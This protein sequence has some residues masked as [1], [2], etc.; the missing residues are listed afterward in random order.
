MMRQPR[1]L[2]LALVAMLLTTA[3]TAASEIYAARY[4]PQPERPYLSQPMDVRL[5][6]EVSPGAEL[7]ELKL[8][9]LPLE[10]FAKLSSYQ[11]VE[12]RQIRRG[13]AVVEVISYVASGRPVQPARQD[14]RGI[15]HAQLVERTSLGFFTSLRSVNTS[16][17]MEPLRLDFRPLPPT[18]VPT[19]FQ[20]AVGT[21]QLSATVDPPQVLPGDLITVTYSVTGRGW[22]GAAHIL[23]P[24]SDPNF[25]SYP[26]QELQRDENGQLSVRQVVVPLNTNAASLGAARLPYFDPA[27]GVYRESVAGPFRLQF[28]TRA[29]TNALPAVKHFQV[30]PPPATPTANGDAA[31][32]ATVT[33]LRRLLPFAT[34]FLVAMLSAGLLYGWRPRVAMA[35]GFVLLIAGAY[36]CQW[37]SRQA[38]LHLQ[39]VHQLTTARLCPSAN[40]RLLFPI[41]PGRCVT[42][43]ETYE[44]WQRVDYNGQ[45]GWIPATALR[46]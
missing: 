18:D 37:W 7:Q 41:A 12:R 32:A 24:P 28:T 23:L 15:L 20:G 30:L 45:R 29:L 8:E 1:M 42:T 25:R 31:V 10:S 21:F 17:R 46:P 6:I 27:V 43:L 4:L 11:Q 44:D 35:V 3:R 33:Q 5:E 22:L 2:V 38:G 40:A 26:P 34:V 19:G 39:R 9:N 16:I 13:E 14:L 36:G